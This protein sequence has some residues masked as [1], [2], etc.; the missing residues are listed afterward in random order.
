MTTLP[1]GNCARFAVKP[2]T[3][4]GTPA[5]LWL[6][7]FQERS[8]PALDLTECTEL[9]VVAP[10]PDDETL[11]LGAMITQLAAAGWESEWS[12]PAM[13]VPHVP[14]RRPRSGFGWKPSFGTNRVGRQI[15]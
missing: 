10:H 12:A 15:F 2:V 9:V 5:P 6:A 4:S 1:A 11:G 13:G 3:H 7:E 8:L 14:A